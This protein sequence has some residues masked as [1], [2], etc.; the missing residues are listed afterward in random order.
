M[1]RWEDANLQ[2]RVNQA[3]EKKSNGEMVPGQSQLFGLIYLF[4]LDPAFVGVAVDG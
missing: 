4:L 2:T 1:G 3:G